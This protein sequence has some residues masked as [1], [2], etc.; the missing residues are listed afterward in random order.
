MTIIISM[1]SGRE[2]VGKRPRGTRKSARNRSGPAVPW[3]PAAGLGRA[4]KGQLVP[5]ANFSRWARLAKAFGID[6][7]LIGSIAAVGLAWLA[8]EPGAAGG[9]L[10]PELSNELGVALIFLSHGLLLPFAALRAGTLHWRLHLIVQST[11]FL[12]FPLIGLATSWLLR[13]WLEPSLA[14]GISFACALPSTVSSS[15]AMTA[16]AGG[17]VPAAVFNATFSSVLGVFLTP[18]WVAAV[19]GGS[20]ASLP[21]GQVVL[22]LVLWLSLPLAVGQLLRPRF[23][24]LA[25]RHA[26]RINALDRVIILFLVYTS[27]CDSVVSG[28][29]LGGG[30]TTVLLTLAF[31]ALVLALLLTTVNAVCTSLGFPRADRIAAVF[32]GSKKSLA[33]GVPM[34]SLMFPGHAGSSLILLP[35]IVYH[36]LQLIV[37]GWLAGRFAAV[38]SASE[39]DVELRAGASPASATTRR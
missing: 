12:V 10:H 36:T 35:I 37:C 5:R 28:V 30:I 3:R 22:D 31:S 34:A 7:F 26:A 20:G 16:V 23:G 33:T 2:D 13:P 17:N 9:V 39:R 6:W 24:A 4:A 32:C 18:L 1:I 29:W 21:L 11:T 14:L 19:M 8:P 27:F 15:V 25:E 38:R